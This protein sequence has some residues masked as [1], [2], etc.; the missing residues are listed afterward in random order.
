MFYSTLSAL[1]QRALKSKSYVIRSYP[2]FAK[3]ATR[4]RN[5][6]GAKAEWTISYKVLK[7]PIS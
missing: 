7:T 6:L 4:T 5:S 3:A 2:T 1:R